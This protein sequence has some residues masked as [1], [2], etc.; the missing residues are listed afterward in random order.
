M[1]LVVATSPSHRSI[2]QE[3]R[4]ATLT[5]ERADERDRW[6]KTGPSNWG[7]ISLGEMYSSMPAGAL[8][9]VAGLGPVDKWVDG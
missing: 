1:G 7:P 4:S 9:S 2:T 8:N 5:I 6:D 3:E